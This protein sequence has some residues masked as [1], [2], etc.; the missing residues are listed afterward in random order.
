MPHGSTPVELQQRLD[1]ERHSVPFLLYR[2]GERRQVVVPLDGE[3]VTIG[4]RSSNDVALGWDPEVSR[5]HAAL[6]RIGP[7]WVLCD[8][9]LSHNGTWVNGTRVSSRPRLRAGGGV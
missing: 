3:T 6:E 1:A 9:G 8:E 2:D 4:R 5:L 7:D